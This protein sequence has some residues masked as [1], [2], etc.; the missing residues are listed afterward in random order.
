M[1]MC[2]LV[3]C[4]IRGEYTYMQN[5]KNY[6]TEIRKM[7]KNKISVGKPIRSVF[8]DIHESR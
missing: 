5:K 8:H 6:E 7:K 2:H 1:S 3:D 4:E